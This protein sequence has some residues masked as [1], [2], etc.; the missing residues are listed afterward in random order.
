MTDPAADSPEALNPIWISFF[1]FYAYS[2][3]SPAGIS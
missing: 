2:F 1:P 3:L